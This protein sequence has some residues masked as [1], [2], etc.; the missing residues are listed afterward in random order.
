LFNIKEDNICILGFDDPLQELIKIKKMKNKKEYY[1]VM[2][3]L[4]DNLGRDFHKKSKKLKGYDLPMVAEV[5]KEICK[6][7]PEEK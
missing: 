6:M 2:E 1:Y 5:F 4:Y 3:Q 7:G